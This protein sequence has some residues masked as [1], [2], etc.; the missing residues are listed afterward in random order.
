ML[1]D[2]AMTSLIDGTFC[3]ITGIISLCKHLL[4]QDIS[5]FYTGADI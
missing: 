3:N 1:T 5:M 2:I 4:L